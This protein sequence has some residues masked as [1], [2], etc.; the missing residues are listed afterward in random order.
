[1]GEGKIGDTDIW[2]HGDETVLNCFI[3]CAISWYFS[4]VPNDTTGKLAVTNSIKAQTCSA[5]KI[6]TAECATTITDFKL[7]PGK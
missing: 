4:V 1:M 7:T 5:I 3:H 6:A 2:A